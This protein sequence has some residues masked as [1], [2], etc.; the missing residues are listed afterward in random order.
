M[1]AMVTPRDDIS[2]TGVVREILELQE[3]PKLVDREPGLK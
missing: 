1:I 2:E 3:R